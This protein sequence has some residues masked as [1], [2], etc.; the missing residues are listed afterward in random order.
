MRLLIMGAFQEEIIAIKKKFKDL[1][2]TVSK[3][4]ANPIIDNANF[5][6]QL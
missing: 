1:K 2:E 5:A 3:H 6:I 4:S